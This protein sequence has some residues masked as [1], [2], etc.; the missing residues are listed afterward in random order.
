MVSP[1]NWGYIIIKLGILFDQIALSGQ[2][3]LQGDFVPIDLSD[4]IERRIITTARE[5]FVHY[6]FD[7]TTINDIAQQSGVA[8]S[9]IY[10]RWKKKEDIFSALIWHEGRLYLDEWIKRIE[11][12]PNGGT[13]S[14]LY[15][16]AVAILLENAFLLKVYQNNRALLGSMVMSIGV[17]QLYLQ[18]Q[19]ILSQFLM[20]LQAVGAVR[21]EVDAKTI[22]YMLN[23]LQFGLIH[24]GE[25]MG[26]ANSPAMPKVLEMVA[27]MLQSYIT[28]QE[29]IDQEAG[30]KVMREYLNR[31]K[32]MLD[33]YEKE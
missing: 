13:F 3:V 12:D 5:L 27:E 1:N 24:M 21:Q 14:A 17:E 29:V 15:I 26:E 9:T 8:K 32:I 22:A 30:K 6:G 20:A 25:I 4:E 10:T 18:R 16:H 31:F 7:K 2:N 11:A 23:S 28:P 33:Q 19:A